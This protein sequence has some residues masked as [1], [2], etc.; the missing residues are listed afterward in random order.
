MAAPAFRA[1]TSNFAYEADGI[2]TITKPAGTVEGDVLI[3]AFV[4]NDGTRTLDTL[5]S[6]WTQIESSGTSTAPSTNAWVCKKVAGASEPASYDFTFSDSF[7]GP[8]AMIAY[9]GGSDVNISDGATVSSIQSTPYAIDAP[10]ITTTVN[11]CL[12]VWIGGVKFTTIGAEPAFTLPSGYTSRVSLVAD[13]D[14]RALAIADDEQA[15]AGATGTVSGSVAVTGGG[16]GRTH[17]FLIA[18]APAVTSTVARPDADVSAGTWTASSGSDLYAMIDEETA[19]DADYITASSAGTCEVALST[20]AEPITGWSTT[21]RYRIQGD[22]TVS[23]REGASTEIASWTHSPGPGS[24]TT[25]E[26]TLSSG[27]QSSITDWADLR[28]RFVKP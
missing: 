28:L 22:C 6:G 15:S 3:A 20:I 24:P 26:Q 25:Y 10:T 4:N 1:Q 21:I 14:N 9:S 17:A 27:E 13:Y 7:N 19:S 12:L 5:P 2:V 16:D 11:E 23:L 18:I 8:A